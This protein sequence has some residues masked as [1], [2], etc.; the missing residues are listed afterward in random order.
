MPKSVTSDLEDG[1]DTTSD[2]D[3]GATSGDSAADMP[4]QEAVVT[5]GALSDLPLVPLIQTVAFPKVS[6]PLQITRPGSL[7]AIEE[8]GK[9]DGIVV[10]V[11]QRRRDRGKPK[12][13]GLYRVGTAARIVRKYKVP[14][15]G[16]SVLF[17]GLHRV[18][19]A[20]IDERPEGL[21]ATVFELMST[22]RETIEMEALRR[23]VANQVHEFAEKGN[24]L[25]PEV[26]AVARRLTDPGWLADLVGYHAPMQVR[27]RQKILET[28]DEYER[29]YNASVHLSEQN[30]ILD[31]KGRIQSKIQDG[32]EKVQREFYLREQLKTIQR[33]LGISTG[34]AEDFIELREAVA[35]S[36]MPDGTREKALKEI[37]RLEGTPPASPEIGV[38]RTYVDWLLELPWGDAP[39]EKTSIRR[40]RHTLDKD[41]YGLS[42][43]KTRVLEYLAVRGLSS[44][45][46]SPIL[47]LAGP[48]GVGK[49]SLGRSI[50]R[51]L[52]RKFVRISLGGVRD[53]A[54]I[55]GHRRT[56]VGA[57]PGRILQGMKQ[58][59]TTNPVFVLD[60][61]D[62]IGRD[63]RGDPSSALLEVLDPEHNSSFSD[64]YLEVGYDL[65]N[66]MFILTA[67]DAGAIPATLR[68]RLE[69]IRLSGYTEDEKIHIARGYLMP[70]QLREHGIKKDQMVM[71]D[72]AI[73][74]VTRNHTREA[75][76]RNLERELAKICRKITRGLAEGKTKT[77]RITESRLEKLLGKPKFVPEDERHGDLVGV[78]NGLAVTQYGGEVLS[79]EADWGEGKAGFTCT[80]NLSD[81]MEESAKTARS[82]ARAK[83]Q[84]FGFQ[85]NLFE[86]SRVH[87]HVPAGAVP[88]DGPSAGTAM[89]T[90]LMSALTGVT[91]RGD[92]AMTGEITL[93]GKVLAIGGLKEKVLAA[94]RLGIGMVILPSANQSDLEDIPRKIRKE[95]KFVLV[96]QMDQVLAV[97][98]NQE[99]LRKRG[100]ALASSTAN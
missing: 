62:K 84:E 29:L 56:Y 97:A 92:V 89:G 9:L 39:P 66:V 25:S 34:Q 63:F 21:M 45:L 51:A 75:G 86:K 95:M 55:R 4:E 77:V 91:V 17:Q 73:R 20:E 44:T 46:R 72:A 47:C 79:V 69:V 60:E 37:D 7:W 40:A 42:K 83:A 98:L 71:S 8:A 30:H 24:G 70:R 23:M 67:N 76:V 82:Y 58:A 32:I 85:P 87:L 54:E 36:S 100:M 59:G 81:V 43:V 99:E 12:P 41:H 13:S 10:L 52:G 94:H 5:T 1:S 49:T 88:K 48:P 27:R 31:V 35:A 33:E 78:V 15:G 64:H 53:E 16:L 11:T 80:G 38:I 68:D 93:R 6:I 28:V 19:I 50:A 74:W 61:V 57:L 65:S 90:A 26:V 14:D 3:P 18:E 2:D 96:D 22:K